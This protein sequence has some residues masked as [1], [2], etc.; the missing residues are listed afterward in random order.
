M[1]VAKIRYNLDDPDDKLA[2]ARS[3][4]ALDMALAILAISN[5][6]RETDKYDKPP[7]TREE[8]HEI[9]NEYDINL[10]NLIN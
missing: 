8:F 7:I 6:F 9:L 2:F 10:D 5:R 4:K 3:T 1:P